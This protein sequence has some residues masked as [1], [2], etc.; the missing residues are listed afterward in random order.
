M[1]PLILGFVLGDMM[2]QNLR[3][4]LA[5]SNGDLHIL[6]GSGITIGLWIAAVV[7]LVVPLLLRW[8]RNNK[9]ITD[10][11]IGGWPRRPGTTDEGFATA[12][13]AGPRRCGRRVA[14]AGYVCSRLRTP[15]P[16]MLGPLVALAVLRVF[17]AP[18]DAPPGARQVGQ[19]VIGTSLG[20]Y[21]SPAGRPRRRRLVAAAGCRR[22]VR[23]RRAATSG[24]L[25]LARLA[26]I[27]RTT[28]VFA[29]VPGRGD[30]DG[31]AGRTLRR[32]RRSR[33]RRA[34]PAHPGRRDRHSVCVCAA[35]R[36]RQRSLRPG[37]GD[38][39]RPAASRC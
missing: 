17:G 7:M 38:F 11:V 34:E 39:R 14:L 23:D 29:S 30:R 35:R 20:L 28:A 22:A 33:R 18:I 10:A 15:I 32:A 3:R 36:A 6:Y 8:K 26:G 25:V 1:A 19:W 9:L 37:H 13:G 2:E 4:A 21:F 16:W 27:D 31:G 12:L 24:G 5:I